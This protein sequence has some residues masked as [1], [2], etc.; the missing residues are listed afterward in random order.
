M[1]RVYLTG[2]HSS[3][4]PVNH[5]DNPPIL[6]MTSAAFTPY[7]Q[8]QAPAK[9]QF[10]GHSK[11][12]AKAPAQSLAKR[13]TVTGVTTQPKGLTLADF[14]GD[15]TDLA[16]GLDHALTCGTQWEMMATASFGG[17]VSVA[18]EQPRRSW[19]Q[20]ALQHKLF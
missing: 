11:A 5:P 15:D 2:S 4:T 9:G 6:T 1:L 14:M 7:A 13:P 10:K 3:L 17:S 19:W 12:S 20:R 18:S 16:G 8:P